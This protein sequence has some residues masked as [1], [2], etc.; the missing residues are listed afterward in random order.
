MDD[1]SVDEDRPE[2]DAVD[3]EEDP[4]YFD[5][6]NYNNMLANGDANQKERTVSCVMLSAN[7]D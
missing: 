7:S 6:D 5:L 1:D 4:A 2:Q 3:E